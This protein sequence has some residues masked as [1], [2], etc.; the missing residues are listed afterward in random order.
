MNKQQ[1]RSLPPNI[2]PGVRVGVGHFAAVAIHVHGRRE[3]REGTVVVVEAAPRPHVLLCALLLPRR[4]QLRR[5][6]RKVMQQPALGA[7]AGVNEVLQAVR[8]VAGL[9][10]GDVVVDVAGQQ[11]PRADHQRTQL[12]EGAMHFGQ[13]RIG[14]NVGVRERRVLRYHLFVIH[15]TVVQGVVVVRTLC[16]T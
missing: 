2:E 8:G 15:R 6:E 13:V 7:P 5:R 1:E 9:P 12:Q 10:H 14:P 3:G 16:S 11:R 4:L